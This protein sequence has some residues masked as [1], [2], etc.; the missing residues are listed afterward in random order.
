MSE[1][2]A[3]LYRLPQTGLRF[4]TVYGP[5]GRPD[6]AMWIFTKAI[7]A[8]EPIRVFNHGLMRRD[9]TYVDDIVAGVL[10]ALDN[11]PSDDGNEKPGGSVSPHRLYNIGNSR[12]EELGR[13]IALLED[14][15]GR[16]AIRD[17]QPMQPGDVPETFADVSAIERDLGF[18][19][20]TPL[21]IGVPRF[22]DWY[23]AYTG[24]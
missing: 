8:G 4:F 1:T 5:W 24:S 19:P 7:L 20:K 12:S 15:C 3:H 6:M 23:R 11:P 2:Y 14:A 22:V 17:D 9:F 13:M 16:K 10:A 18:R 21:D